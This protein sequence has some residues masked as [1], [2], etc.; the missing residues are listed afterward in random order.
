MENKDIKK[1]IEK[2]IK[3]LSDSKAYYL[4][5][6][7]SKNAEACENYIKQAKEDLEKYENGEEIRTDLYEKYIPVNDDLEV[8]SLN[9]NGE[10]PAKKGSMAFSFISLSAAIVAVTAAVLCAKGCSSNAA[11]H[12]APTDEPE[13]IEEEVIATADI[14]DTVNNPY[15]LPVYE[16][17]DLDALISE[18]SQNINLGDSNIAQEDLVRYLEIINYDVHE[19]EEEVYFQTIMQVADDLR[20]VV[21]NKSLEKANEIDG[22]GGT[23][24]TD[25]S[26]LVISEFIL[27]NDEAKESLEY[28]EQLYTDMMSDDLDV[29]KKAYINYLVAY[30]EAVSESDG[31]TVDNLTFDGEDVKIER[32]LHFNKM[33]SMEKT[34]ILTQL[35]GMELYAT[36]IGGVY[37]KDA[38]LDRTVIIYG[39]SEDFEYGNTEDQEVV[40][41]INIDYLRETLNAP[42]CDEDGNELY[43]IADEYLLNLYTSSILGA[44]YEVNDALKEAIYVN[45]LSK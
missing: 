9:E 18:A 32:S 21:F 22:I 36:R 41:H 2:F 16:E 33:N 31:Y 12:V 7:D 14:D 6:K 39:D 20:T 40:K 19:N 26:D 23:H 45:E 11:T 15:N 25:T 42:Y 37:F 38:T 24:G 3:V 5:Q 17:V 1:G 13:A 34:L 35:Q 43:A 10:G 27:N 28:L 8:V 29:A 30:N 4:A 44:Q